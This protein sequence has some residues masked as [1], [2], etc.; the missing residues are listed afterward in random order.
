MHNI[1]AK[2]IFVSDCYYVL[3]TLLID[4]VDFYNR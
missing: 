1:F 2:N 4:L 3:V